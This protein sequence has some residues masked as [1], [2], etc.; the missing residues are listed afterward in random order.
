[1]DLAGENG[2]AGPGLAGQ[3]DRRVLSC[4]AEGT[5]TRLG[6]TNRRGGLGIG[7]RVANVI[8]PLPG[9]RLAAA[10]GLVQEPNELSRVCGQAKQIDRSLVQQGAGASNRGLVAANDR[11]GRARACR[12]LAQELTDL[13]PVQVGRQVDEHEDNILA[14]EA[15]MRLANGP[16]N[17]ETQEV[18]TIVRHLHHSSELGIAGHKEGDCSQHGQHVLGRHGAGSVRSTV[19]GWTAGQKSQLRMRFVPPPPKRFRSSGSQHQYA[20]CFGWTGKFR[21]CPVRWEG[22]GDLLLVVRQRC[23]V[24][25][26]QTR[27]TSKPS[28][29]SVED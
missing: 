16:A 12:G 22:R 21:E 8:S 3:Q 25:G 28:T 14:L 2:L 10:A 5:R 15:Q 29:V 13:Y 11:G 27:V 9:S 19:I 18:A 6:D 17:L 4:R 23:Q 24:V 20:N 1:M 26:M 7:C